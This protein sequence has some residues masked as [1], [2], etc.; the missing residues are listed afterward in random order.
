[1][2]A[3]FRMRTPPGPAPERT[4]IRRS[5]YL[6][7]GDTLAS[8]LAAL[9]A[10]LDPGAVT[11]DI[12][13]GYYEEVSVTAVWEEIEPEESYSRKVQ[14][15]SKRLA[16]YQAW[17]KENEEKINAHIEAEKKQAQ[18]RHAAK[19][20]VEERGLRKRLKQIESQRARRK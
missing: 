3:R 4:K 20:A 6:G 19:I 1:M 9:P 8:L 11:F 18:E 17:Y 2:A 16:D 5:T 15:Y 14:A 7:C 13:Y 10:G 12:E